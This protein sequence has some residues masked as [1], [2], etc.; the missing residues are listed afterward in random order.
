MIVVM[1]PLWSL[2]FHGGLLRFQPF[3]SFWAMVLGPVFFEHTP[4]VD[5][6]KVVGILCFIPQPS[7]HELLSIHPARAL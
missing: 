2:E 6:V 1:A 5:E 4:F 7:N 3:G